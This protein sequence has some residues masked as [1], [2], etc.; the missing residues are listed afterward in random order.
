MRK[1]NFIFAT[2]A[3]DALPM[4][5]GERL[6]MVTRVVELAGRSLVGVMALAKAQGAKCM[7]LARISDGLWR[8]KAQL[9]DRGFG[10]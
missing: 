6:Y 9:P 5:V 1:T 3:V 8:V 2:G 4:D 10:R 7:G